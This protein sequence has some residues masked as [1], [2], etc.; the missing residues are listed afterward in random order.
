MDTTAMKIAFIAGVVIGCVA[1]TI[2][3]STIDRRRL[4]REVAE[5]WW[6]LDAMKDA[7]WKPWEKSNPEGE[8]W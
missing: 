5:D 7:P 6:T 1:G 2:A 8:G 3:E 4:Y